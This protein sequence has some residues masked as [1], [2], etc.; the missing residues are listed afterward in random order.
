MQQFQYHLRRSLQSNSYSV[1]C[2]LRKIKTA[3][4]KDNSSTTKEN[5]ILK[6]MQGKSKRSFLFVL[7]RRGCLFCKIGALYS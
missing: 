5:M 7:I 1:G 6:A 4:L 3:H 2:N